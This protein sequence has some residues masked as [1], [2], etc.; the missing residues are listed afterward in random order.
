MNYIYF[1]T[2]FF[3]NS[4][5][6]KAK[7]IAER[8]WEEVGKTKKNVATTEL[9]FHAINQIFQVDPQIRKNY[10]KLRSQILA[11]RYGPVPSEG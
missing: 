9:I 8:K 3:R 4:I 5:Y 11:E 6:T 1:S 10:L 2:Q 7:S